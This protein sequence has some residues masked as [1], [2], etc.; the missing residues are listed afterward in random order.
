MQTYFV[1]I[2]AL[3]F[4]LLTPVHASSDLS[5]PEIMNRIHARPKGNN[6][7][8]TVEMVLVGT[9][10]HPRS[11]RIKT[12]SR[13]NDEKKQKLFFF[14]DPPDV[15]NTAFLIDDYTEQDQKD[16]QWV[17]LPSFHRTKRVA[18][19]KGG[20]S[21]MGS[22][23][24]HADLT[25]QAPKNFTYRLLKESKVGAHPV[26]I[27]EATP[28]DSE[29]MAEYGYSKSYLLVR[30]DNFVVI[31]SV[32]WVLGKNILKYIEVKQLELIDGIWVPMEILAKTVKKKK[33]LHQTILRIHSIAFD[34]HFSEDFFSIQ[35]LE[36]GL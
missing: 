32:H 21:F 22:D 10:S 31:R 24:S 34:Q 5:A 29:I 28:N 19:G 36:Q 3:L 9:S 26:W 15:H 2:V 8:S 25:T 33:V 6:I 11:Y 16:A 35:R 23:F 20:G 18:M 30:K 7:S 14:L 27:I 4:Q 13:E 12:F 17:F 1:L